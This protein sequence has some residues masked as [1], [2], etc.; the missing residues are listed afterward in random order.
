M[1]QIQFTFLLKGLLSLCGVRKNK[2]FI[3][4]GNRED[5]EIRDVFDW[6]NTSTARAGGPLWF[7]KSSISND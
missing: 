6:A 3:E 5:V 2:I 4:P 7:T 1:I